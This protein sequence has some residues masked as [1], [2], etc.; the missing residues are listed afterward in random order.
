MATMPNSCDQ[1]SDP[2]PFRFEP[3]FHVTRFAMRIGVS[4]Y[5]TPPT[6]ILS[7]RVDRRSVLIRRT[8]FILTHKWFGQDSATSRTAAIA[9]I[10]L[11]STASFRFARRVFENHSSTQVSSS[12]PHSTRYLAQDLR[13]HSDLSRGVEENAIERPKDRVAIPIVTT[14][15]HFIFSISLNHSKINPWIIFG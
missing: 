12:L 11:F 1:D 13:R 5:A 14:K 4:G 10:Q 7:E 6:T 2:D 9:P 8:A 3:L 15:V